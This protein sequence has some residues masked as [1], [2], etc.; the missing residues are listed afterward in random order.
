MHKLKK[1]TLIALLLVAGLVLFIK[2]DTP[3]A[4]QFTD[5]YLRPV[6]GHKM[7][8]TIEKY[9]YNLA[10]KLTQITYNLLP[11]RFFRFLNQGNPTNLTGAKLDLT[12]TNLN[13]FPQQ[14]SEGLWNNRPLTIF[15]SQEV[16]AYTFVRPDPARPFAYVTLVKVDTKAVHLSAVAGTQQPGGPVG[17]FGPGKVPLN[18][19]QSGNLI[20]AFDGGF[21]Y[22][23]G[24][25]GMI[26]SGTTYLPL[27]TDLGTLVGYKDGTLKIVNYT[28]QSLGNNIEFVRQNCPI[29]IDNGNITTSNAQNRKLWGRTMTA[30]IY[31]WRSGVGLDKNGDLIYAV[32]NN[33]IP[34]TLAVALKSAGAINAIQLDIN[35]YWVRFNIFDTKGDGT[36]TTSTLTKSLTSG[37]K[38]YLTG[39]TK[40]FFY[41]YKNTS[42]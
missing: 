29:L 26:V 21:Q 9:Y 28:G 37:A 19:I 23:D 20:A 14:T 18:I 42:E 24:Q 27:K 40:D 22:R 8:I 17:N 39:Y 1:T 13:Y 25:Y 41:L 2:Y 11:N 34:E 35:P 3:A 16:M 31:T 6:F 38:Q 7:V 5:N 10:D 32:G 30:D 15:P 12:P 36:Y 33:I 4:A